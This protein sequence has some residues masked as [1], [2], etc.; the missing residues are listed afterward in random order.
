MGVDLGLE[1]VALLLQ[2]GPQ[3]VEELA[4]D[5]HA[6]LLHLGEHTHE[7]SLDV[8]VQLPELT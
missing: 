8:L 1:L 7:R 4:V 2:V 5:A 6:D 3:V